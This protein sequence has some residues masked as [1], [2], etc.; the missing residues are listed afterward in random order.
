MN[1]ILVTS[2]EESSSE[3]YNESDSSSISS[4]YLSDFEDFPSLSQMVMTPDSAS[5]YDNNVKMKKVEELQLLLKKQY[6]E[7]SK[8][9]KEVT[10]GKKRFERFSRLFAPDQIESLGRKNM[11]G[12][13]WSSE[14]ISKSL[15][16]LFK[17]KN[18]GYKYL[19]K[20]QKWPLPSRRTLNRRLQNM[21]FNAGVLKDVFEMLPK[22]IEFMSD[23]DKYCMLVMDEMSVK[24]GYDYDK[25]TQENI[26]DITLPNE[27]GVATH[28]LVLMLAGLATRWKQIVGYHFTGDS[29]QG[30]NLKSTIDEILLKASEISLKVIVVTSDMG[31]NNQ[32]V[33]KE[34]GI[35]KNVN[36]IDHPH[37]QGAYLYFIYDPPHVIKC[38]R[39]GLLNN[40]YFQIPQKFV[41][42]YQLPSNI[43]DIDYVRI[44][45]ESERLHDWKLCPNLT[46]SHFCP[47]HFEAMKVNLAAQLIASH[48]LSVGMYKAI[49]SSEKRFEHL[50]ENAAATAWFVGHLNKWFDY[51]TSRYFSISLSLDNREKYEEILDFFHLTIEL[52]KS[53]TVYTKTK[54]TSTTR[55]TKNMKELES[56][57]EL[58]RK[59]KSQPELAANKKKSSEPWKPWQTS[60]IIS[61]NSVLDLSNYLLNAIGFNSLLTGRL[62][63]D[64]IENL[65]SVV[66]RGNPNPTCLEF[67]SGLKLITASQFIGTP[68]NG[69]YSVD[70]GHYLCEFLDSKPKHISVGNKPPL[71]SN[72]GPNIDELTWD[73][74]YGKVET[75]VFYNFSGYIARKVLRTLKKNPCS[76]DNED[77]VNKITSDENHVVD[78]Q[79]TLMKDYSED[80]HSL[81]YVSKE[82]FELYKTCELVFVQNKSKLFNSSQLYQGLKEI[83]SANTNI[84]GCKIHPLKQLL[85]SE[86]ASTRLNVMI[87]HLKKKSKPEKVLGMRYRVLKPD[88][89]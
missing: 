63:Q 82:V 21:Q 50:D 8:L 66:R 5:E 53:L 45:F 17:C 62:T 87:K 69:N 22:K 42:L 75:E 37:I 25:S 29:Y 20:I 64:C 41:D 43:V 15:K 30:V 14:T 78:C 54:V 2:G 52:F 49:S 44:L 33:Y 88:A 36:K 89:Q 10:F 67:K 59:R 76:P 19:R 71:S 61:T 31:T 12:K 7:N 84:E 11:R 46:E 83:M 23:Y 40:L 77:C 47:N 3:D 6:Y 27:N 48:S 4:V 16:I 85:C 51:M 68:A 73:K 55:M 18:S 58:S 26:G 24:P 70:D 13:K 38:I 9:R 32:S 34:Y 39:N 86:Y 81:T 1:C 65:F 80:K 35:S 79:F 28:G 57:Q 74:L 60:V 56:N 72:P